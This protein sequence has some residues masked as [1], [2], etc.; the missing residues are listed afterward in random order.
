[1]TIVLGVSVMQYVY[2]IL[3]IIGVFIAGAEA[4]DL[5]QQLISWVVGP[6]LFGISFVGILRELAKE[7]K[8]GI[9]GGRSY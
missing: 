6:A 9:C 8:S 4:Q 7:T 1:M 5:G 3:L 2:I